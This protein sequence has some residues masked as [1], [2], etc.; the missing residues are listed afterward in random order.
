MIIIHQ[1]SLWVIAFSKAWDTFSYYGT[2]TILALYL[3]HIFHLP[4]DISYLIYGTYT[5]LIFTAPMLGGIVADRWL[6]CQRS[7]MI[8]CTLNIIGNLMMISLIWPLFCLGLATSLLGSGLFKGNAMH[9]VGALYENNSAKKESAFTVTYLATNVGGALAPLTYGLVAYFFRWNAVFLCSAIGILISSSLLLKNWK[10]LKNQCRL[11]KLKKINMLL[12]YLCVIFSCCLLSLVFYYPI[13]SRVFI[14]AA[15]ISGLLYIIYNTKQAPKNY[16]PGL[17]A[18]IFI[19]FLAMFYFA[20]G[21]QVGT[22]ITFF[23]QQQIHDGIIKTPLPGST[24]NILYC[25]FVILLAPCVTFLWR[26]LQR[27]KITIS[28][29][30]KIAMG[31]L[32]AAFGMITFAFASHTGSIYLCISVGYMFLSV[33]ELI[34][35]PAAFTAISDLSPDGMR[36]T[37]M[38]CWLLFIAIGSYLSSI[39]A[40]LS[41]RFAKHVT[42]LGNYYVSEF[43]FIAGF[44]LLMA[45]V[46]FLLAPRLV[47]MMG[48]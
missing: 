17:V 3:M 11:P 2:Q 7:L 22:T 16:Q 34:I 42:L 25:L 20:A 18:L 44:T 10:T 41:G 33:G 37:M 5:A 4:K 27:K 24:F 23:I 35:S 6:G 21:L 14:I 29:P 47:K 1:K 9:L 36:G 43:L 48:N 12:V 13:V 38:G 40:N 19:C 39:L 31:I 45:V 32:L 26:Y 46:T 8:G 15:I 30:Y 28:I